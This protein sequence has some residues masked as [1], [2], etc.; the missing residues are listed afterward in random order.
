MVVLMMMS[1]SG[2]VF[3]AES[4]LS[5]NIPGTNIDINNFKQKSNEMGI[6]AK[7]QKKLI[8]KL[9]KGNLL[10]A[11]NP[12]KYTNKVKNALTLTDKDPIKEHTFD[13]GSKVV[14]S[15]TPEVEVNQRAGIAAIDEPDRA[16][17]CGS[18]YCR[19]YSHRVKKET[20]TVIM[21]FLADFTINNGAYDYITQVWDE[22]AS[23][24]GG[25]TSTPNLRLLQKKETSYGRA[26][27]RLETTFT[28]FAGGASTDMTLN[29]YVG[30][31]SY[32]V[33]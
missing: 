6:N 12:E 4:N 33:Y 24:F 23:G 18:G 7:T 27:A 15:I 32:N 20:G 1:V 14:V 10:D 26:N 2:N 9:Q 19:Y 28:Y 5:G 22:T 11:D 31:D 21:A 13:D 29:L 25:T 3:A 30:R 8:E 16:R 17:S